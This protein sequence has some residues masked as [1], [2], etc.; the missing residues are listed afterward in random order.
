M[1][2][3]TRGRA[4]LGQA[5]GCSAEERGGRVVEASKQATLEASV[6]TRRSHARAALRARGSD[7]RFTKH[8]V[9]NVVLSPVVAASLATQQRK[10]WGGGGGRGSGTEAA[11]RSPRVYKAQGAGREDK[12]G[13]EDKAGR[14]DQSGAH[15]HLQPWLLVPVANVHRT[16]PVR[17]AAA[18]AP[19][20]LALAHRDTSADVNQGPRL[21]STAPARLT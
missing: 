9:L 3:Y 6:L 16:L 11:R 4:W 18:A 14:E 13:R 19:R 5:L 8:H 10:G 12:L 20:A 7:S 17:G 1:L 21:S 2:K 15:L